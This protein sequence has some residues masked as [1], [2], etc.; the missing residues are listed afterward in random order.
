MKR[1]L[2]V[3]TKNVFSTG[4]VV[5]VG[6][7]GAGI[8]LLVL[9]AVKYLGLETTSEIWEVSSVVLGFLLAS[10]A[11]ANFLARAGVAFCKHVDL[12]D[13]KC[14]CCGKEIHAPT[15]EESRIMSTEVC[16]V[17]GTS[18]VTKWYCV[19]LG[20][21]LDVRQ[22]ETGYTGHL[23]PGITTHTETKYRMLGT[24]GAHIC[25]GCIW[26]K[27]L[28]VFALPV[29]SLGVAVFVCFVLSIE[30]FD[31]D[32]PVK[33][34]GWALSAIALL[35]LLG[36]AAFGRWDEILALPEEMAWKLRQH[37]T[38]MRFIGSIGRIEHFTTKKYKELKPT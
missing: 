27:G 17:C 36:Y 5:A 24:T 14:R 7:V 19:H 11:T 33:H 22:W 13:G 1:Y 6:L 8:G 2:L 16:E 3:A 9:E 35:L 10:N 37:D 21:K 30:G 32:A 20:E 26:K 15:T 18:R 4:I 29:I 38:E 25:K 34:T 28:F 31:I 23:A 12:V